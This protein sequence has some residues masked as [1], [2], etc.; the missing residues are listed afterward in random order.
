MP[1]N[2]V[3]C[4]ECGVLLD[5]K[6]TLPSHIKR[7]HMKVSSSDTVLACPQCTYRHLSQEKMF[8]H[9]NEVHYTKFK[10][11]EDVDIKAVEKETG[12]FKSVCSPLKDKENDKKGVQEWLGKNAVNVPQILGN[13][14]QKPGNM[15]Q[16]LGKAIEFQ[17]KPASTSSTLRKVRKGLRMADENLPDFPG[18]AKEVSSSSAAELGASPYFPKAKKDTLALRNF[19]YIVYGRVRVMTRVRR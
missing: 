4:N 10:K 17:F 7:V 2:T 1:D 18:K 3:R 19:R 5:D 14:P 11:E 15:P 8:M 12:A 13:V 16:I 9:I 6:Y